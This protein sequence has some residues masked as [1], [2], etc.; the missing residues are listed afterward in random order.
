LSILYEALVNECTARG[1]WLQ[2][3]ADGSNTDASCDG[4]I[5]YSE[6]GTPSV[7]SV[8]ADRPR[9][10]IGAIAAADADWVET[11]GWQDARELAS[12]ALALLTERIAGYSGPPRHR[13]IR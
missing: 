1:Y 11:G 4:V 13:A 2:I 9:V 6:A 7:S 12:T 10:C 5:D 3:D 8:Q